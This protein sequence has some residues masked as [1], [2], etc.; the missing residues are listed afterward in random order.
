MAWENTGQMIRTLTFLS[1]DFTSCSS[2]RAMMFINDAFQH[3]RFCFSNVLFLS[4]LFRLFTRSI[5]IPGSASK[6]A[7]IDYLE[8][9]DHL[10]LLPGGFEEATLSCIDQDRIFLQKRTGFIR[11]C[12]Q[13]G[14]Q[15]RPTYVFG[16]RQT[17][18]NIQGAFPFRLRLNRYGIPT[19]FTL[20]YPFL[21][22]L[23]K[24]NVNLYIVV[25]EP[26]ALPK[27]DN[28]SK[29]D[30]LKWHKKYSDSLKRI[31]EDHKE[32]AYGVEVA[33]TTKLE[34]W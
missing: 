13:Y 25:G 11:L 6:E 29:E 32:N 5:G 1:Y 4:P 12:L 16:E 2:Y 20:G 15:V 14:I 23:P 7:M 24:P 21:P 22:L 17:Y 27:I 31:F 9:G 19:I 34:V 18:W 28:P 3:V 30:V 10:G 26:I 8:K 33:K